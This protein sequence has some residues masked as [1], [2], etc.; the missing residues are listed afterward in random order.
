MSQE[1]TYR[2][3]VLP[4]EAVMMPAVE[5]NPDAPPPAAQEAAMPAENDP[6]MVPA[7]TRSASVSLEKLR[8][9]MRGLVPQGVQ[10]VDATQS[11]IDRPTV[12]RP[13]PQRTASTRRVT[14]TPAPQGNRSMSNGAA[15][16]TLMR[17]AA[18]KYTPAPTLT[19]P[20]PVQ[21]Q[22]PKTQQQATSAPVMGEQP[23]RGALRKV[24]QNAQQVPA[25]RTVQPGAAQPKKPE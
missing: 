17:S 4:S 12:A 21:Q 16:T 8:N 9:R 14:E 24:V 20:R 5:E 18:R 6:A 23:M 15:L 13:E 11:P 3:A 2:P 22:M 10:W 1:D 7:R 19:P 25:V